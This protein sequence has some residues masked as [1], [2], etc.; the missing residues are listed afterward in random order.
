MIICWKIGPEWYFISVEERFSWLK[1]IYNMWFIY[2]LWMFVVAE[3]FPWQFN[4][5]AAEFLK[6]KHDTVVQRQYFS[7][8]EFSQILALW[9]ICWPHEQ[10]LIWTDCRGWKLIKPLKDLHENNICWSWSGDLHDK[11]LTWQ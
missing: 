9:P 11:V 7:R 2:L 4:C 10:R 8:T 5:L 1:K 6:T 3:K